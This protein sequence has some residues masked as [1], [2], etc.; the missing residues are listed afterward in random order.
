ME[1]RCARAGGGG[2]KAESVLSHTEEERGWKEGRRRLFRLGSGCGRLHC[3]LGLDEALN[4][5]VKLG[6]LGPFVLAK[7]TARKQRQGRGTGMR[8]GVRAGQREG[9]GARGGGWGRGG[10]R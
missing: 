8:A 5:G 1:L 4:R 9:R 6:E 10:V 7:K 2:N 3:L